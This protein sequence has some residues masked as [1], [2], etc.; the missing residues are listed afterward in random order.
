VACHQGCETPLVRESGIKKREKMNAPRFLAL[1]WMIGYLFDQQ[2][3][4][5]SI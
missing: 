2:K 4:K 3:G 5:I 1:G